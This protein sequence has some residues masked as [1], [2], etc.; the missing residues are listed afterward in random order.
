MN[1]KQTYY[2]NQKH[3]KQHYYSSKKQKHVYDE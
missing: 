2:I 1:N 3:R